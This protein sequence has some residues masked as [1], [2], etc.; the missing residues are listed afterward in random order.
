M[1]GICQGSENGVFVKGG[2]ICSEKGRRWECLGTGHSPD[3]CQGSGAVSLQ[4]W[5]APTPEHLSPV[6]VEWL[7]PC[8][9]SG[10]VLCLHHSGFTS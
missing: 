8:L 9:D 2:I 4:E 3:G 1:K 7:D 6:S 5:A 10:V